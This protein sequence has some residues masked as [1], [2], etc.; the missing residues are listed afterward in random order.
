MATTPIVARDG[1][2]TLLGRKLAP[3]IQSHPGKSGI[4][5]LAQGLDAF[6]AR[7]A[8]AD[9]AERTLDVQYY[10]WHTDI[11]GCLL[12]D[13][14][15]RAAD[16]GVRVRLLLDDNNTAGMDEV[17]ADLASHR[18]IDVR[19]FNPFFSRRWRLLCYLTDFSRLNRRM[20]NKSFTADDQVTIIG[21]RNIGDEYFGA[22]NEVQFIDLDV[23]AI[24]DVVHDVTRDFDR[25]WSYSS[26]R[27]IERL[28]GTRRPRA[29]RLHSDSPGAVEEAQR[30]LDAVSRDPLV[31]EML[32]GRLPFEWATVRMVSDDPAKIRGRAND[33]ELLWSRL[34]RMMKQPAHQLELLSAYFVPGKRGVEHFTELAR[35]GV[36]VTVLT[37]SLEATDVAA[38]HA[39]YAK[40]RKPLLEAGV[41]LFE[42]KRKDAPRT[43]K[44]RGRGGSSDSSL[45][46]KTSAIDRS[47]A[48]VGSFNFD[49]RS[50]RLNTELAFVIE[51]PALAAALADQVTGPLADRSYKVRLG[52]G[53]SLEW[54]DRSEGNEIVHDHEPG[55]S[56]WRRLCVAVLSLLPIEWLL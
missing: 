25:Y 48:F 8:L 13:A 27:P 3:L 29:A 35:R 16:R 38:V 52:P 18:N 10:I 34:T 19:L 6:A 49:P 47:V 11:S 7:A 53:G 23:M 30:F 51:S 22:G 33:A 56:L 21:G 28:L 40:R 31:Q 1:A 5:P 12:F 37:N 36:R 4:V 50:V 9:A 55:A 43:P 20:H 26:A 45:H 39:G 2:D 24:G 14:L 44:R 17:L 54:V 41:A 32:E 42:L 15:R 46:A